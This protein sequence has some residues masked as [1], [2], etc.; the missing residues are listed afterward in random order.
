MGEIG[1]GRLLWLTGMLGKTLP[2]RTKD[3]VFNFQRQ[4]TAGAG[5]RLRG[6]ADAALGT[7]GQRLATT[8][9]NLDATRRAAAAPLYD[10]VSSVAVNVDDDILGLLSRTR[11]QHGEAQNLYRLATGQELSLSG[12]QKGQSVPFQVLDH[13]KQSLDDAGT[14]ARRAG[15]N[16]LGLA[17]DEARVA[18]VSKLDDVSPKENGQSIYRAARNAYA[19]PSQLMDA[20]A[21]GRAAITQ[22]EAAIT[23][24][25]RGLTTNELEAFRIGAFEGLREKRGFP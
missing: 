10:R 13:L 2:G 12:L 3:A 19:G 25:V 18:L 11:G 7:N 9:E 4:R 22:D 6:A 20:A 1:Q 23:T 24:A 17:I 5:E 15:N 8:L 21:A 16:K 14:V